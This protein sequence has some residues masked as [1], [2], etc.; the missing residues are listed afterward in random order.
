MK[1]IRFY[2]FTNL[3]VGVL[4]ATSLAVLGHMFSGYKHIKPHLY[5]QLVVMAHTINLFLSEANGD[6][7]I[8][9]KRLHKKTTTYMPDIQR[10]AYDDAL[11]TDELHASLDSIQF[12]IF[13]AKMRLVEASPKAPPIKGSA[14]NHAIGFFKL[15]YDGAYWRAFHSVTSGGWH[16][17]VMQPHSTRLIIERSTNISAVLTSLLTIPPLGVFIF[18]VIG[19]SLKSIQDTTSEIRRRAHNNLKPIKTSE[20][21]SEIQPLI[22]EL[23]SLF[24]RLKDNF[25]RESRFAADAAHEL[26]TPLAALKTHAQIASNSDDVMVIRSELNKVD[27][28]VSRAVHTVDQLLMLSRTMPDAYT[29]KHEPIVLA[30]LIRE[31]MAD[32]VPKALSKAINVEFI[33]EPDCEQTVVQ[34]HQSTLALLF[35]NLIDNAIRYSES[36]TV[37]KTVLSKDSKH[38]RVS[39]IDQGMGIPEHYRTRIFERFFRVVGTNT[40]GT[41]LGLN[42]VKQIADLHDAKL[43]FKPGPDQLGTEFYIIFKLL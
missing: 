26:K 40:Q 10:V 22:H 23:N 18:I 13:D 7:V 35:V 27:R 34:G 33:V 29:R 6:D 21:P 37:I 5:A 32:L 8:V 4:F 20:V 28:S 38:C 1:S 36:D 15:H 11:S 9:L 12:C 39:V 2:L 3:I 19:R 42:I 14:L 24:F 25:E 41:G 43:S 16:V 31:V 30:P 17:V